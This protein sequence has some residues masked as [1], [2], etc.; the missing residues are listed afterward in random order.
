MKTSLIIPD[1]IYRQV[2]RRAAE[3][4][5]TIS[6]LVAEYLCKGL[7][8]TPPREPL[9]PLPTFD[10]GPFLVDIND[11]EAMY[12]VLDRERDEHLYGSRIKKEQEDVPR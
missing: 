7:A 3:R 6:E 5:I 9:P 2:K 4:K 8:K 10:M 1:P 11:K 12:E